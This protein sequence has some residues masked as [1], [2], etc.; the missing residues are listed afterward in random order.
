[1]STLKG[2]IGELSFMLQAKLNGLKVLT[3]I[4]ASS[5]YDVVI[6]NQKEFIRVQIKSTSDLEKR[7]NCYKFNICRGKASNLKYESFDIDY[8]ALY[9]IALEIFYII[10]IDELKVKTVRVYP[11]KKHKYNKYINAW[12]L[13]K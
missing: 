12:G 2:D 8:F 11:S 13:L 10:P 4:S 1:M 5:V 3:P 9:I 6:H 7:S